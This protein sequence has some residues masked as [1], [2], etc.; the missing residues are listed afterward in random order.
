MLRSSFQ[1]QSTLP[2]QGETYSSAYIALLCK[3]SIHSPYTGRDHCTY[4]RLSAGKYFNPLS[5]YRERQKDRAA[6]KSW[7]HFNPLSLYRERRLESLQRLMDLLYF[8]PLSLYRERRTGTGIFIY[9]RR[10][11]N[12]LSLYRERRD[13]PA[14]KNV[15]ATFQSTLPIQGETIIS[16]CYLIL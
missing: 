1:F 7:Q 9:S 4:W 8:N 16:C 5:L 12:P 3:I 6:R 11:F 13:V 10:Y 15:T 2:I 14:T